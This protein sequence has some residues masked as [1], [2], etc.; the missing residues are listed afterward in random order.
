MVPVAG[1]VLRAG[2]VPSKRIALLA[3]WEGKLYER[4]CPS[5]PFGTC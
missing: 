3:P 4:C 5:T 2:N 1:R